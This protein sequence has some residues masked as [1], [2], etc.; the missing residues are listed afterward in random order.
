MFVNI[1][2][3]QDLD[4]PLPLGA[5]EVNAKRSHPVIFSRKLYADLEKLSG[6][7][8]AK[9]LFEK[10]SDQLCLVEPEDYYDDRDIDTQKDFL[11]FKDNLE[12]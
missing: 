1:L 5:I 12:D 3:H 11:E 4:S 9:S 7:V 10:Y 6:D 2:L 8:G